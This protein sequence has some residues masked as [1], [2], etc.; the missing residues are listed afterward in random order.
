MKLLENRI[1]LIISS[2]LV[3][4]AGV[5]VVMALLG[6]CASLQPPML[7]D[8]LETKAEQ[9][10]PD[11]RNRLS[12]LATVKYATE[13]AKRYGVRS[14]NSEVFATAGP[15][16][17]AALIGGATVAS[18]APIGNG[19]ATGLAAGAAFFG[20]VIGIISPVARDNAFSRGG[21]AILAAMGKYAKC[22]TPK[23]DSIPATKF[24]NCGAALLD[25]TNGIIGATAELMVGNLPNQSDYGTMTIQPAFLTPQNTALRAD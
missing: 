11:A 22:I 23:Y 18:A 5:F 3:V 25:T 4:A 7:T 12:D 19:V 6:G 8:M 9:D 10:N 1:V 16:I 14:L 2:W 13:T 17:L 24:T 21:S 15:I 20:H